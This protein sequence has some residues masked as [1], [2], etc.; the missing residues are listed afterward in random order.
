MLGRKTADKLFFLLQQEVTSQMKHLVVLFRPWWAPGFTYQVLP[1]YFYAQMGPIFL[2]A[3]AL[4]EFIQHFA[5]VVSICDVYILP[6]WASE[7]GQN[8]SPNSETHS[9]CW[10]LFQNDFR[11]SLQIIP[12]EAVRNFEWKWLMCWKCKMASSFMPE[13][14]LSSSCIIVKKK[15]LMRYILVSFKIF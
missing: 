3:N 11:S 14:F 1:F 13:I 4:L 10:T 2:G 15:I 7:L 12:A 6:N 9:R 8:V 5:C